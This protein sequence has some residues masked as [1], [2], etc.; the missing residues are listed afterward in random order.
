MGAAF[1]V[2]G[3]QIERTGRLLDWEKQREAV[4]RSTF[5]GKALV[6]VQP[7]MNSSRHAI[8]TNTRKP[9][10]AR[11]QAELLWENRSHNGNSES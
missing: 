1:A 10:P 9:T 5:T 8:H 4:A 6:H 2:H 11:I 3:A 7:Y